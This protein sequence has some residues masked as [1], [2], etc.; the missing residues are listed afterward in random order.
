M[1]N[2]LVCTLPQVI[3]VVMDMFTDVDILADLLEAAARHVP[4][5]ILL[6]EQQAHHF[7]S[8]VINSKVN[9]DLFRVS[10]PFIKKMVS[11]PFN[12]KSIYLLMTFNYF[13]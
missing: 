13:R 8:M 12:P 10:L 1:T 5:Y 6:D 3:A 11:Y 4:V 9:W 2:L 7:V